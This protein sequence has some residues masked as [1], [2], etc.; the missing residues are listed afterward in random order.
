MTYT[1]KD[2][3]EAKAFILRR[4]EAEVSMQNHLDEALLWAARELI[5]ISYK[6]KI[7]ASLF[8][9]SAHPELKKEVDAVMAKLREMLYDYTETLSIAVDIEEKNGIIALINEEDHGRT[10]KERID[11]YTNRY[12]Y[13]L[14][15]FVGAALLFG[16]GAKKLL[17]TVKSNLNAPYNNELFRRAV[18]NKSELA[19]KRIKSGGVSYGSGHS[20]CARTLLNTLTRNTVSSAWM[21]MYGSWAY[22]KGAVGFYSFRGSSYP[23]KY[24]QDLVGYHPIEDYQGQWHLN[25]RC[26]FVFVYK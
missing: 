9:F 24:C 2:I 22:N 12:K 17:S 26:Y 10:L 3:D 1:Q 20:N 21:N 8:R 13:E 6:Y 18:V 25:C 14:E 4:V 16:M 15:A 5:R 7:K 23:C 19:A 11:I